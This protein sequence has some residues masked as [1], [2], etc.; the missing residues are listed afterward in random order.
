M[1]PRP[2]R[3]IGSLAVAALT[4]VACGARVV[5]LD[6]QAFG[7]PA[8]PSAS[9]TDPS[10]PLPGGSLPPGVQPI[11]TTTATATGAPTT[12]PIL[13]N[14]SGGASDRGVTKDTIK[15][16]LIASMTGPLPGQFD[17]AVEAVDVHFKLINDAGGICGRRVQLLIRDDSGD[18]NRNKSIAEEMAKEGIFAFVGS[19]SA[20][21]DSGIAVVSRREKIPDI[22]FPLTWERAENPYTFGVPG[23]LQRETIGEGAAGSKYL[24]K[25]L[26]VEQ[27]A[28]FWLKESEVSIINAWGFESA[29]QKTSGGKLTICHEQ[30]AGVLDNNYTNYVVAMKGNCD[31]KRTAVY[32]TMENNAN[33]KL[34]IAMRD[35]G[36]KPRAYVPTFSSYLPSFIEDSDGAAEGAYMA[37]PQIPFERLEQPQSEWT[38]GTYE[39]KRYV[40][41]LNHYNPRHKVPGSWGGPAWASAALFVEVA[42][43]CGAKLTRA[44]VLHELE[45]MEP[46]SANGFVVPTRPGDHRIYTAD[47][48]VRVQNGRFVEI[49]PGDNTAPKGAPDFWDDSTLFNWQIY[50]CSHPNQFPNMD[51][52]RRLLTRC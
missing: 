36:F 16:G 51:E 33:I 26:G 29:M 38:P 52:K 22:G 32:T 20:P 23:Q 5:P 27:I 13:P 3:L 2:R 10:A 48:I 4:A 46:F 15:L 50:M 41:T 17:A 24:N 30:P 6:L 11:A 7:P 44:C 28:I 14:C 42:T 12:A 31:P 8:N 43:R 39:L 49:P 25:N 19:H 9:P 18:G 1:T 35:Q 34:A 40:D 47:L 45:T 37:M 21:D